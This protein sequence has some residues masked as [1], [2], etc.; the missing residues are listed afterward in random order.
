MIGERFRKL[1]LTQDDLD[2]LKHGFACTVQR[3]M[4]DHAKDD[5]DPSG[6]LIIYSAPPSFYA[7]LEIDGSLYKEPRFLRRM[8]MYA[9]LHSDHVEIAWR[10]FLQSFEQ[11]LKPA[12]EERFRLTT[13]SP[14][15]PLAVGQYHVHFKPIQP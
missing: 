11:E 5:H 13:V 1:Q 10:A 12:L 6:T 15:P 7:T 3:L 2:S 14:N 9:Q 8:A 4:L